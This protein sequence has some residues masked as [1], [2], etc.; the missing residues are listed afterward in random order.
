MLLFCFFFFFLPYL[1]YFQIVWR[2]K[3]S[4]VIMKLSHG[5]FKI[6][7]WV[8]ENWKFKMIELTS[9]HLNF[10]HF[11]ELFSECFVKWSNGLITWNTY[12]AKTGFPKQFQV[13]KFAQRGILICTVCIFLNSFMILELTF[14]AFIFNLFKLL[15]KQNQIIN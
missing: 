14:L 15:F 6:I 13:E 2:E 10:I 12:N 1:D 5:W 4:W 7:E 11:I 3:E 8:S 9:T